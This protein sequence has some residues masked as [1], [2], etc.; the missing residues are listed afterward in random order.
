M[1]TP[2]RGNTV[3]ATSP[4]GRPYAVTRRWAPWRRRIPVD[5][6]LFVTLLAALEVAV[7]L[8]L[9]PVFVVLRALRVLPWRVEVRDTGARPAAAV[10]ASER[11]R[12][13]TASRARMEA[14]AADVEACAVDP[15]G[16]DFSVVLTRDPVS[17]GDDTEDNTTVLTLDD[18]T[19][20][21]TLATLLGAVQ[22]R[23]R[24]VSIAGDPTTWVLRES[25]SRKKYGRPLAVLVLAG[26][27]TEMD[28]YPV[29]DA[30]FRVG[31]GSIFHLEYLLT[32]SV[33]Q[34]FEL[35][36]KDRGVD[37]DATP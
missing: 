4:T 31:N 32:Q 35:L 12:G 6:E 23:G 1:D 5:P 11:V 22:A 8:V 20:A 36:G 17:M 2:S 9:L 19:S 15:H 25:G 27:R 21:P 26:T 10:V 16:V 37:V 30:S 18:R 34:T 3:N 33:E 7:Q 24:F 29:G 14:W 13:W 28:L